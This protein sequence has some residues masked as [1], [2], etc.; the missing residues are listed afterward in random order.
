[1][2]DSLLKKL[3]KYNKT[4]T[5]F[6]MPGHKRAFKRAS[7]PYNIDI[8]EV[9]GFDN[10]HDMQGVLKE[11]KDLFKELYGA[12]DCFLLVNGST[13]G[14]L[15]GIYSLSR[16]NK[17]ILIARNCHKSVYNASEILGLSTYYVMPKSREFGILG[18]IDPKDVEREINEHNI[19]LVVI[20]SPTYDGVISDISSIYEICKKCGAYL[21][22][23]CAHGAH[24]TDSN[25]ECDI[26]VMSLHK[27]LPSLTQTA[28]LNIN[29]SRVDA[30]IVR[31]ALSIFETSSPS[32]V[33]LASIDECARFMLDN[34]DAFSLLYRRLDDFYYKTK[35]LKNIVVT[36]FDDMSKIIIAANDGKKLK[37]LLK[38]EKIEVE[39]ATKNYVLAMATI[40]DTKKTLNALFSALLKIDKEFKKA[41]PKEKTELVLSKKRMEMHDALNTEGELFNVF[42]S[43]GKISLEYIFAYPPGAPVLVPGEVISE[44]IINY[45]KNSHD[46]KSTH[47]KYPQIYIKQEEHYG[48]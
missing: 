9:D 10:L 42:D 11:T 23:D 2:N 18:E 33:L 45:L 12:F 20:T 17:N 15:A 19:G 48:K 31:H 28:L 8:T 36:H 41:S 46:L 16:E 7:I 47:G 6:H 38:K 25:P 4:K 24:F 43:V 5:P 29:S 1:M 40:C 39:M 30:G 44:E 21:F 37:A 32:Y 14:I 13:C 26:C 3:I 34:K 27:T 35:K 22:V